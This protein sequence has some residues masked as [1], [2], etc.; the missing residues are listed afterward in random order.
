M[1]CLVGPVPRPAG[2]SHGSDRRRHCVVT[3]A[4]APFLRFHCHSAATGDVVGKG[5]R[6]STGAAPALCLR[7]DI[8]GGR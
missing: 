8:G 5:A 6:R 3:P 4:R 1:P 2:K 7:Q